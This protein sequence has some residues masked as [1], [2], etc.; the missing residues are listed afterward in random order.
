MKKTKIVL[1]ALFAMSILA[2]LA[3]SGCTDK[4]TEHT[5]NVK[6]VI[7]GDVSAADSIAYINET[8]DVTIINN[9]PLPWTKT[10]TIKSFFG[11]GFNGDCSS[12]TLTASIYID[13]KLEKTASG[14]H[15]S[16]SYNK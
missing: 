12:G 6:Y 5:Y 10:L 15:V 11:V 14:S 8:N 1:T 4:E 13:D 7:T 3:F 16:V 9:V 2:V